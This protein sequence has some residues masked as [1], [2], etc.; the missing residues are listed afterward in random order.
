MA[1]RAL[2]DARQWGAATLT[3]VSTRQPFRIAD[4]AGRTVFV[5][6]MAIWCSNCR[7]QQARFQEALAQVDPTLVAYVVLT[8]DP[9]ETADALA[10]YR[11][12]Q[13]FTGIY[14]VAGREVSTALVEEFGPNAINPPSVP[15][16]IV[17]PDGSI[18]FRAGP[19]SV[20]EILTAIRG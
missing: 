14:A 6:M 7:A 12:Q 16:V 19:K 1:V 20:A 13:G 4:L 9:G 5:E 17:R 15:I 8:V 18:E 11:A 3:D 2:L 10:R